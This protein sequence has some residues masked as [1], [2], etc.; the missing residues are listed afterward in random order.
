MNA[1]LQEQCWEGDEA[2]GK[3][4]KYPLRQVYFMRA[5]GIHLLLITLQLCK[6]SLDTLH[7][8]PLMHGA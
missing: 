2:L 3:I 1:W 5:E 4:S 7:S 8:L 6:K